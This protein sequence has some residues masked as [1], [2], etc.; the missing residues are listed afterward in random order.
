MKKMMLLTTLLFGLSAGADL[1]S[2]P[3]QRIVE[4]W[5]GQG[6]EILVM[7][8]FSAVLYFDCAE[9]QVKAGR[10]P[11][12]Q[13]R[14]NA[15]GIYKRSVTRQEFATYIANVN[16]RTQKMTLAVKVGKQRPVNYHIVL[17]QQANVHAC[18]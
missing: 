15:T 12:G 11:T 9:G 17:G 4:Y 18:R 2:N 7:E 8:D 3:N 5:G 1:M 16:V 10:W 13:S 6:L 14:I